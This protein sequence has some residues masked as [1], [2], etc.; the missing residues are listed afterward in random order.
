MSE[1]QF[2]DSYVVT[3][4]CRVL[5]VMASKERNFPGPRC[6]NANI[7]VEEL[8]DGDVCKLDCDNFTKG[9]LHELNQYRKVNNI[10]WEDFYGW[11]RA[12]KCQN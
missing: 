12:V 6:K 9:I 11:I 5:Q 4:Y 8:M 3:L 2:R 1:D 7:S 10:N